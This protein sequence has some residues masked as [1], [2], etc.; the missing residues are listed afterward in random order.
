MLSTSLFAEPALSGSSE[1]F[2]KLVHVM[3]PDDTTEIIKRDPVFRDFANHLI[4]KTMSKMSPKEQNKHV[5]QK[6]R[7]LAKLLQTARKETALKTILDLVNPANFM[8][9]NSLS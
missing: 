3:R 8:L 7:D 6:L 5:R 4:N 1:Q 9:T 2:K